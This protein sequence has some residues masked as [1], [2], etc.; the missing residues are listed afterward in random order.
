MRNISTIPLNF[1]IL[2]N[3][4]LLRLAL[5]ISSSLKATHLPSLVHTSSRKFHN[6]TYAPTKSLWKTRKCLTRFYNT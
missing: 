5:Q 2:N 6:K 4:S 3:S 1:N